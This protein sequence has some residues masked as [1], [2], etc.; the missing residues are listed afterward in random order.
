[1]KRRPLLS[2]SVVAL[3]MGMITSV[4]IVNAPNAC[5]AE[6]TVSFKEDIL[7]LLN[8]AAPHAMNRAAQVMKRAAWI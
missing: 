1:M 6:E 8:G 5:A 7:P 4:G 2:M 3:G